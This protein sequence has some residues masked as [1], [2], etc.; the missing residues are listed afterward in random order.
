MAQL[1]LSDDDGILKLIEEDIP[2]ERLARLRAM[3]DAI[4]AAYEREFAEAQKANPDL[5]YLPWKPTVDFSHVAEVVPI[6]SA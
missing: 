1:F 6:A 4:D 2:T 5:E 3:A